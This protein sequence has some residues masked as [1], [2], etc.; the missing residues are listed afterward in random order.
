MPFCRK[1]PPTQY[2]PYFD[3]TKCL[4]CPTK[5]TSPRGSISLDN[6]YAEQKHIC[7]MNSPLCGPHG[8]C[9]P[10]NDNLHLYSCLCEEGFTGK[11]AFNRKFIY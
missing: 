10:E 1:C 2:Q 5:M 7:Q 3:Q 6:C 8:I 4:N 9:I 11:K